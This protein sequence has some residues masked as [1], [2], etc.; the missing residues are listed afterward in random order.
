MRGSVVEHRPDKTGVEG[1][2]PSAPTK[3]PDIFYIRGALRGPA[4]IS[5]ACGSR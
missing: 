2:I 1:S 5:K 4:D 3:L